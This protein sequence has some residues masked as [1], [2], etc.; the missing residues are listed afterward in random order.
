MLADVI[1][2]FNVLLAAAEH[3][4]LPIDF[5]F[6][7]SDQ[8]AKLF[9]DWLGL[10]VVHRTP[11]GKPSTDQKN[12]LP[13]LAKLCP[14]IGK[15]VKW[16]KLLDLR[17]KYLDTYEAKYAWADDGFAHCELMQYGTDRRPVQLQGRSTTSSC[18]GTSRSS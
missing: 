14:A 9:H 18:P 1:V 13:K 7:S 16:K 5:N 17:V 12:A 3:D 2:D 11:G 4:P 6:N 8:R 15:Y 10:P